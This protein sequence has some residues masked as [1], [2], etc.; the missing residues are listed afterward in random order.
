M[1]AHAHYSRGVP[2]P[3]HWSTVLGIVAVLAAL[4][5]LVWFIGSSAGQQLGTF[6][7]DWFADL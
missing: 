5:A 7:G 2:Q 6:V 4:A 3:I 1:G